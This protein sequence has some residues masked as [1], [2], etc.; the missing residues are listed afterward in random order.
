LASLFS[1][2]KTGDQLDPFFIRI[3]VKIQPFEKAFPEIPPD[4]PFSKGGELFQLKGI[5]NY[6]SPPL[7]KGEKGGFLQL[8]GNL[9]FYFS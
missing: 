6:A 4:L 1:L 8:A 5:K 2:S 9:E 7:K 3:I